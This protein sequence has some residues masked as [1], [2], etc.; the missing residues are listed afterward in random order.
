MTITR[1]ERPNGTNSF[2]VFI[3]TMSP[4]Y[5]KN[6]YHQ[7]IFGIRVDLTTCLYSVFDPES[8]KVIFRS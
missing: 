7:N 5:E 1:E 8:Q 2:K 4:T 6:M 3:Y